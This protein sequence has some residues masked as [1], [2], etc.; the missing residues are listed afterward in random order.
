MTRFCVFDLDG[1]LVDSLADL[2]A[3]TNK[4]LA[5]HG[6]PQHPVQSYRRFVGDGVVQLLRRAAPQGSTDVLLKELHEEFDDYYGAHCFDQTRPYQGCGELLRRLAEAGVRTAVL[7]NKPDAFACKIVQRLF[8]DAAFFSVC[9][10]RAGVP[11][12]PDPAALNRM[13]LQAG[14]PKEQCL[15]VGDSDVDVMTAHNA[16]VRCCGA[17]W[18]FRGREELQ[19]AGADCL[20][21]DP[22]GVF[23]C[24]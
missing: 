3:A 18:G 9:G 21:Q 7:S 22:A 1:T 8:P 13:I 6:L 14:V 20:A 12:K 23:A 2:A 19:N 15:Y 17:L 16:G 10:S 5:R 24:L 11:K 4:A